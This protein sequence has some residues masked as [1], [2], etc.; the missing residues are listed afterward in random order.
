MSLQAKAQE[1][2]EEE[3]AK[4]ASK[5]KEENKRQKQTGNGKRDKSGRQR[6]RSA[7]E[8]ELWEEGPQGRREVWIL[9][10]AVEERLM[11]S[12]NEK[13]KLDSSEMKEDHTD[14]DRLN[15]SH[16]DKPEVQ[17]M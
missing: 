2:E 4:V 1:K 14:M 6:W 9:P 15:L 10:G 16:L 8:E 5:Q 13:D 11:R 3:E 7:G 12:R 17:Y